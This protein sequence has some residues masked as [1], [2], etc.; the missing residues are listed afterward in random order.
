MFLGTINRTVL[1]LL[2]CCVIVLYT[3]Q[4]RGQNQQTLSLS[5]LQSARTFNGVS[6]CH[7]QLLKGSGSRKFVLL[8]CMTLAQGPDS[9]L[10]T[11]FVPCGARPKLE[12]DAKTG[13]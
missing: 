12:H 4:V 8:A 9:T 5:L 10:R 2:V 1:V 3:H 7:F 6:I 13:N 11:E